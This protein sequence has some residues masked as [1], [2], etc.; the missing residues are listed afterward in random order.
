MRKLLLGTTALAAAA[1]LSTSIA[2]ADVSISGSQEFTYKSQDPGNT[3]AGRSDD[4]FTIDS[5]IKFTLSNKTDSGLDLSMVIVMENGGEDEA[6][7]NI[8]GGFG[9]ITLGEDDG[10]GDKLTRTA[11]DLVGPDALNDGGGF[12]YTGTKDADGAARGT[13]GNLSDDNADLITDINDT[14]NITYMLPTMGG[15][16]I[17]ASFADAGAGTAQNGDKTVIAAKYAFESGAVNGA[18]HY[19]SMNVDGATTGAGSKN[20]NSMALD[21]TSGPFRAVIAKAEDDKTTAIQTEVT[22][23]GIQYNV[24]NGLTLAA[25][26]TQIEENTGGETVDVTT[27]SAKYTIASGLD[28]YL[29]YHDYDYDAGS[30]T[31]TSDDGSWTQVTIKAAF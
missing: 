10:A 30:S 1:S 8:K 20:S 21:V 5:D 14:N 12:V 27:V 31:D 16:S 15:L 26:G 19:G 4:L 24:G 9:T 3:T 25:V 18:I 2:L 7:L 6:Y 23:Y 11:H 17:G 22:D 28:A 29:T 13:T